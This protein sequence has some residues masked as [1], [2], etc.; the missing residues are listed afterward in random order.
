MCSSDLAYMANPVDKDGVSLSGAGVLD[1]ATSVKASGVLEDP[2]APADERLELTVQQFKDLIDS[3]A[4]TDP[5]T[6]DGTGGYVIVDTADHIKAEMN[7]DGTQLGV[8]SSA[9]GFIAKDGATAQTIE[10]NVAQW[11][12]LNTA[13]TEIAGAY[14]ISDTGSQVAS[15]V[16]AAPDVSV[17]T[18]SVTLAHAD[19]VYH[20]TRDDGTFLIAT[21]DEETFANSGSVRF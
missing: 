20:V 6:L 5:T 2:S 15:V 4:S 21:S 10:L 19:R 13:N 3:A 16:N 12:A 8:L 9:G 17:G 11:N 1:G 14:N 7:A 18:T